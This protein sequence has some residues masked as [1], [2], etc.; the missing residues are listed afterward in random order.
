MAR[1]HAQAPH[2]WQFNDDDRATYSDRYWRCPVRLVREGLWARLW[3]MPDTV[4]G[5]GAMTSLLPVFALHTWA[6]KDDATKEWTGWTYLS[7]RRM[8][9][10]AGINKDTATA[11]MEHLEHLGILESQRRPRA[12]YE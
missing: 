2:V 12:K 6:E 9:T 1:Q 7:R 5:G 10:L 4:R 8:A 3:R 11:A